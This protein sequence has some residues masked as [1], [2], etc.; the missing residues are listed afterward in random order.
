[1]TC[2]KQNNSVCVPGDTSN[3]KAYNSFARS[4]KTEKEP[5][6][7]FGYFIIGNSRELAKIDNA[8]FILN[9]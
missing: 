7:I 6:L 2:Q 1:L 4:L 5:L 8:G 9:P 3:S